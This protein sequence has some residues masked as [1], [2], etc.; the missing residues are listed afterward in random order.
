MDKIL[1]VGSGIVGCTLAHELAEK[2]YIVNVWEKRNHV[3]G[4]L[5]DFTDDYG[6]RVHLYGPHI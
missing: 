1:I 6:I 3:G 2:G 5:F 4:N